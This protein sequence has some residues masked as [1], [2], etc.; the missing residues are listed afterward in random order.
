[1]FEGK[2]LWKHTAKKVPISGLNVNISFKKMV[3]KWKWKACFMKVGSDFTKSPRFRNYGDIYIF[4]RTPYPIFFLLLLYDFYFCMK[5]WNTLVPQF[6]FLFMKAKHIELS[7]TTYIIFIFIYCKVIYK[8]QK[9]II[10]VPEL[11]FIV[12]FKSRVGCL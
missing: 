10:I 6:I 1:M 11:C 5:N 7:I 2:I 12:G 3:Y 4:S 9:R 8:F